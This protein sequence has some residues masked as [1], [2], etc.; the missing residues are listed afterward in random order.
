MSNPKYHDYCFAKKIILE[1]LKKI[2]IRPIL[3]KF[4]EERPVLELIDFLKKEYPVY[5]FSWLQYDAW[6]W[7]TEE[8]LFYLI[9]NGTISEY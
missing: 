3:N 1:H 2:K 8:D 4:D 7:L 6:E 9:K 5:S